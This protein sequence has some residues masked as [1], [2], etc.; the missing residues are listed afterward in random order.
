MTGWIPAFAGMTSCPPFTVEEIE[1]AVQKA[2]QVGAR[3]EKPITT[4]KWGKL[5]LMAD[6]FGY[7]FCLVQ[8]LGR[9]YDEIADER[10]GSPSDTREK[11]TSHGKSCLR[12]RPAAIDMEERASAIVGLGDKNNQFGNFLGSAS[13]F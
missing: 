8:F 5:A 10:A 4:H 3:L 11:A 13:T 7:G 12:Q 1:G 9:G 2:V 6:S